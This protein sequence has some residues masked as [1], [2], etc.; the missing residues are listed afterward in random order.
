MEGSR[1]KSRPNEGTSDSLLLQS[2]D[3]VKAWQS[4]LKAGPAALQSL[5]RILQQR[6][7]SRQ[8]ECAPEGIARPG[9]PGSRGFGA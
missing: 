5:L 1:V 3:R 4:S 6:Q 7:W 9:G 2:S 8:G